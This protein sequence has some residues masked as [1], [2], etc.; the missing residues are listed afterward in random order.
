MAESSTRTVWSV[1]G[2]KA[3]RKS[4]LCARALAQAQLRVDRA[5]AS[6]QRVQDMIEEYDRRQRSLQALARTMADSRNERLFIEQLHTLL[7]QVQAELLRA[8][9]ERDAARRACVLAEQEVLKASK[10]EEQA[11]ARER[12]EADQREGA[13]L[14]DWSTQRHAWRQA[15][16]AGSTKGSPDGQAPSPSKA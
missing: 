11:S 1:L 7:D 10:L 9:G 13:R 4:S 5:Q 15:E 6:T 16:A 12:Q 3:R 2:I 14:D 8:Q